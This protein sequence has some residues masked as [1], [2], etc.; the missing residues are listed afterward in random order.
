MTSRQS[1]RDQ[2]FDLYDCHQLQKLNVVKVSQGGS[3][4]RYEG[5]K[6][7]VSACL[8]PVSA[9]SSK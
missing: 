3:Y 4:E 1:S 9:K 2:W 8:L 7:D 5:C 6:T